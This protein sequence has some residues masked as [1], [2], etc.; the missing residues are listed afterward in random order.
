MLNTKKEK[1]HN[2]NV[3][4]LGW[5]FIDS[6]ATGRYKITTASGDLGDNADDAGATKFWTDFEGPTANINKIIFADNGSGMNAEILEGSFTLGFER[7]RN[8]KQLGKFGVGGTMGCLN[9]ASNKLTITRDK[10]GLM[11][12]RK[13]DLYEVKKKDC[14]G[15]SEVPVTTDMKNLLNKY[16][17][18]GKTGTVIILS[19]FNRNNFTTRKDN[20][21]KGLT[22]YYSSVYCEKI[23]SGEFKVFVDGEE[24]QP[25]DPLFWYH[26]GIDKVVD[27]KI[28]GTNYRVRL[29][30][31]NSVKQA[32]R[33]GLIH[34]QGGYFFR[35]NR[36]IKGRVTNDANWNGTWQKE[37][38][39]RYVRWG[40]YFDA[41]GD[42]DMGVTSD[43]SDVTPTQSIVDKI[44]EIIM[45]DALLIFN[46][47]SRKE[48]EQSPD[49]KKVELDKIS[50]LITDISKKDREE[51]EICPEVNI[52]KD[53]NVTVTSNV[54]PFDLASEVEIPDFIS[55]DTSIGIL[56]EPFRLS[57]NS[58][59]NESKWLLEINTDHRY[60][61]KYYLN[62]SKEVRESVISWIIPYAFSTLYY[63]GSD[64]C[65]MIDFRDMFSR[66]LTQTTSKVDKL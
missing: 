10:S 4:K 12:A 59:K 19:N 18:E 66:K 48:T 6:I 26:P 22:N 8:I 49:D 61:S 50:E 56:A 9:I 33:G 21:V 63:H 38:H 57:Q 39:Y 25:Q 15:T 23:G 1:L 44:R 3:G 60:I 45:P 32:A 27:K 62:S 43:K 51:R 41:D 29:V 34:G 17:G 36:M 47:T 31:L 14:W 20:L 53:G 30:D 46:K 65:N 5:K 54:V 64:E 11:L 13:Y 7:N 40:V 16:V 35:C 42:K 58:N 55:K 2:F 52:D 28:P 37:H 24:I